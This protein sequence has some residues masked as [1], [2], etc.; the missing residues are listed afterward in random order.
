MPGLATELAVLHSEHTLTWLEPILILSAIAGAAALILPRRCPRAMVGVATVLAALSIA[1]AA[2]AVDTLGHATSATFPAGGPATVGGGRFRRGAGPLAGAPG[3]GG[4]RSGTAGGPPPRSPACSAAARRDT[5]AASRVAAARQGSAASAA[6]ASGAVAAA[7]RWLRRRN[8]QSLTAAVRYA[9]THG[10]GTIAVSSQTEAESE[11]I[12]HGA[13][14]AGIGGFSG[15]ESEV[16]A[17]WLAGEIRTGKIRWVLDDSS[18]VGRVW[19][20]LRRRYLRR[21][22]REP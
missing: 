10:G 19:R 3:A 8:S 17:A 13:H 20:R 16:S 18:G 6:A 1:P 2:W 7:A 5:A 15:N 21:P 9:N 22:R 12:E 4:A 11:V 14:V